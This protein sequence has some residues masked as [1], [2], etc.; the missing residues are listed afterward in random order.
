MNARGDPAGQDQK[1]VLEF[2]G[3]Q[4]RKC[5]RIDTH[6]SIVFLEDDRGLKVK[7]AVRLSFL[8]YSSST[9]A[10]QPAPEI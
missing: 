6:A 2:L 1:A 9:S 5:K 8:A 4:K 7:R 10:P 3:D